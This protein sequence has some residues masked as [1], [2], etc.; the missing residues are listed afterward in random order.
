[1]SR[2]YPSSPLISSPVLLRNQVL[3]WPKDE[4]AGSRFSVAVE[5]SATAMGR[6]WPTAKGIWP[7][8]RPALLP[9][10]DCGQD[11]GG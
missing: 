3:A 11:G 1:M 10:R 9:D 5:L 8:S 4:L 7:Q 6:Q 2:K